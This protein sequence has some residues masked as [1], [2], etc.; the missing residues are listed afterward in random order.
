MPGESSGPIDAYVALN[1]V[2]G[3]GPRLQTSLLERFGSPEAVLR[4]SDSQL[5]SV[6]GIG[7]KII[8][9]MRLDDHRDMARRELADCESNDLWVITHDCVDYPPL[10]RQIPDPPLVLYC[11]GRIEPRDQLSVAI[12]GSRNC[13]L[14][15]RR[16]AEQFAGGLARAGITVVSGLARGIDAVAHRAALQAGGRTIAV[17]ASGLLKMYPPEHTNFALE[18][19]EQ[20][21]VISESPL[22]RSASRGLFPQR[23]RIVSGMCLGVI[24]IEASRT[25]GTLHT[26]RHAMEQGR[27]IFAVPG[28]L[29]S[30][31]S[32]GCH[33]LIR[34]GVQ[35]VRGVDDVLEELGP[36]MQPVQMQYT[37]PTARKQ[38]SG[39]S[40]P[41]P[42]Q[43]VEVQVPRQLNLSDQQTQILNLITN[44]P[45]LVD[46]I[47]EQSGIE[48][49]RV[50]S[51]LTILQMKKL[52]ER[53]PGNQVVRSRFVS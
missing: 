48:A 15:G 34:D 27:E 28:P 14:Y 8:D 21:A 39:E 24:V 45:M 19:A 40:A 12:V 9:T 38:T 11:R 1:L 44:S 43:T 13:T 46:T 26:A 4:A 17:C 30:R 51:T 7:K 36:L 6:P 53:L 50:L 22:L 25:S 2:K 33:Q 20:G 3:I 42:P 49:S 32:E 10:L 5:S 47:I 52:V 16:M 31:E 37:P 18:I 35:L 41:Q 29:D 23:N